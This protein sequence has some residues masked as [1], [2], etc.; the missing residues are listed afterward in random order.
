MLGTIVISY[1]DFVLMPK[2][3]LRQVAVGCGLPFLN[4]IP[5][6]S[7]T[8]PHVLP[9]P[10]DDAWCWAQRVGARGQDPVGG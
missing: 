3:Q 5:L 10:T 9:L 4:L 2:W 7:H 1:I 6:T 8:E